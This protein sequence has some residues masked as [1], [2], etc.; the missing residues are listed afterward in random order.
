MKKQVKCERCGEMLNA[1]RVVFLELEQNTGLYYRI[2]D[3]PTN[4]VS[5][6]LFPFGK[7]C[8]HFQLGE[9][10]QYKFREL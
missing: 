4:G 3:F 7:A 10:T 5:Q 1:S 9:K 2:H 8:A 6:G